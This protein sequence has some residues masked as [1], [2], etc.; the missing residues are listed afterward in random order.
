MLL[1]SDAADPSKADV[2]YRLLWLFVRLPLVR[3]RISL[4]EHLAFAFSLEK[5]LASASSLEEQLA[6]A[7]IGQMAE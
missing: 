1:P 7:S 3:S 2:S 5:Q 6:S 4:K